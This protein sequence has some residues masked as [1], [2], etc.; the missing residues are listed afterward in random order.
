[1]RNINSLKE[2]MNEWT[3]EWMGVRL[4][5]VVT[6]VVIRL[7][8]PGIKPRP[9]KKFET[10]FLLHS[11][12][13]PQRWWRRVIRA[14]WGHKTPLYIKPEYLSYPNKSQSLSLSVLFLLVP[15]ARSALKQRRAFSVI[16]PSTWNEL[17]LTLRLLPQNNM[18]SF[19]K[20]LKTLFSLWPQLDWERL[21]V[22]FL[23]GRYINIRNEWLNLK[24]IEDK[25][26]YFV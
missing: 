25:D 3:N 10:R 15:R 24:E 20:L 13:A 9:G 14:E 17:P 5:Q 23:K 1:M 26:N 21:W 16:G 2:W 22:G 11:H 4:S 12:F 19:W 6:F 18:S 7:R 8:S